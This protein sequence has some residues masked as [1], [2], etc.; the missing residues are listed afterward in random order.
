[1]RALEQVAG[2]LNL[3]QNPVDWENGP[4]RDRLA[5]LPEF[6][7]YHQAGYWANAHFGCRTS[8]KPTDF[9]RGMF[10]V[11]EEAESR[12]PYGPY[13]TQRCFEPRGFGHGYKLRMPG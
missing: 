7:A 3:E 12:N 6:A 1:M 11:H 8:S 13:A 10:G 4:Q 5:C 9:D 2:D